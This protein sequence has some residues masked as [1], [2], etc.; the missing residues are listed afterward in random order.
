MGGDYWS[1]IVSVMR[2][3][4]EPCTNASRTEIRKTPVALLPDRDDIPGLPPETCIETDFEKVKSFVRA[5]C[6]L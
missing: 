6:Y 4:R 5:V 2:R 3:N 1:G